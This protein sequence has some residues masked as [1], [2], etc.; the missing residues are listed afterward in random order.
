VKYRA[1]LFLADGTEWLV[2]NYDTREEAHKA[3]ETGALFEGEWLNEAQFGRK[4]SSYVE[5]VLG[6]VIE[7]YTPEEK[8]QREID[9]LEKRLAELRKQP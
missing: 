7:S 6:L 9:S 1:T 8:R 5:Q 3:I 2:G 4:G